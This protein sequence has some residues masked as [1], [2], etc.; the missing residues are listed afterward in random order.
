[1]IFPIKCDGNKSESFIFA[2]AFA[3][4][5][6][7]SPAL[8]FQFP[9]RPFV[10]SFD[11]IC[12]VG[13]QPNSALSLDLD[14]CFPFLLNFLRFLMLSNVQICWQIANNKICVM[15]TEC[16]VLLTSHL[17]TSNMKMT[18]D[19]RHP[20]HRFCLMLKLSSPFT[21][22]TWRLLVAMPFTFWNMNKRNALLIDGTE[23]LGCNVID[24]NEKLVF[25]S[26][27]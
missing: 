5:N 1:M 2:F 4:I 22:P 27:E 10:Y 19:I 15:F 12:H 25:F 16:N 13:W 18:F 14:V 7:T 24:S 11:F 8:I 23:K 17:I 26:P 21:F 9:I 3:L 20:S 6:I